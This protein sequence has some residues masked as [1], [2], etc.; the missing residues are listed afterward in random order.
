MLARARQNSEE[1]CQS[2][3]EQNLT[4]DFTSKWYPQKEHINCKCNQ[5]KLFESH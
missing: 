4:P 1:L 5:L 3:I 2:I